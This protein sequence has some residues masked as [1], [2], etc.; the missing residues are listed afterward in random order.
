MRAVI[1]VL[2]LALAVTFAVSTTQ[3]D[4]ARPMPI[5]QPPAYPC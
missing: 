4:A 1:R 5:C 3:A 2:I